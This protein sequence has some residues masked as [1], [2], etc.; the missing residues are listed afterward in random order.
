MARNLFRTGSEQ[1]EN[2]GQ[3][4]EPIFDAWIQMEDSLDNTRAVATLQ[5][6]YAQVQKAN[7][8]I[9]EQADI[10]DVALENLGTL[11]AQARSVEA[12]KKPGDESAENVRLSA[13]A[14]VAQASVADAWAGV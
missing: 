3:K 4:H 13:R 12:G 1:E 8:A 2:R 11:V 6:R 7:R 9:Q 14:D 10:T 5:E